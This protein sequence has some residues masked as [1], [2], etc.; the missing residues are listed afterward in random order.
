MSYIEIQ[1][2]F[3]HLSPNSSMVRASH[4][5]DLKVVG[6]SG[7]ATPGLDPGLCPGETCVCPGEILQTDPA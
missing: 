3:S 6:F 4:R 2:A 5:S 1:P 7:V